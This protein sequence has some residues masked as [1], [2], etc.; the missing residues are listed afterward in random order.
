MTRTDADASTA[1]SDPRWSG[2]SSRRWRAVRTLVVAVAIGTT[3]V[4]VA[5]GSVGA[6]PTGTDSSDGDVPTE[7]ALV[8]EDATLE[9]DETETLRVSLS[10]ASDGLA[11]FRLTLAVDDG[12]VAAVTNG[13]YPD[14]YGLTTDPVASADGERISVEA[15]D[16]GDEVTPGATDVSL[17]AI[18]V[19]GVDDG[20]TALRVTD[21]QVD[22][23]GGDSVEPSLEAGAV[24]VGVGTAAPSGAESNGSAE[25]NESPV[26]GS[27]GVD[28]SNGSTSA[29][30]ADEGSG[31]DLMSGF[32]IGAAVVALAVRAAV[33][34]ERS[35]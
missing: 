22:A 25:S 15:A 28:G 21:L 3:L 27:T 5:F 9:P 13:S 7:P 17:A 26:T 10:E 6:A 35:G 16:L 32:A 33:L 8:V 23:D 1:G 31:D 30:G 14:R 4:A 24:T 11:G 12:D 20:E 34:I 19:T 2:R 18:D 29:S